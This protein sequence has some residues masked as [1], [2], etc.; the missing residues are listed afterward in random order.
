MLKRNGEPYKNEASGT[1]I[2]D[3]FSKY[4]T[5]CITD[6]FVGDKLKPSDR[7]HVLA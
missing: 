6:F 7:A 5:N 4:N 2:D 3:L 1:S